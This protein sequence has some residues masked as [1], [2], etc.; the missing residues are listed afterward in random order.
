MTPCQTCGHPVAKIK[1]EKYDEWRH[2][3]I[4]DSGYSRRETKNKKCGI[5]GC[6]SPQPKKEMGK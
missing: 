2:L 1:N 3:D 4:S 6:T 5:C